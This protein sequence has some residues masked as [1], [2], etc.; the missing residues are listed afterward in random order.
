M[1]KIFPLLILSCLL[2]FC[3][4]E[5]KLLR[6]AANAVERTQFD[7]AVAAYDQ[8]LKKDSNSF[9][10][11]AGKG[12]VLSEFMSRHEQAIPYLETALKNTPDKTKPILHKNLGKSY[13]FVGNYERALFYYKKSEKDND[14]TWADYDAFLSKRIADCKYAIE[15]PKIATPE[16]Q[17]IIN[18][19]T[20]INTEFPEYTPVVLGNKI[21]F[22]SKRQDDPKEK[23][24]QMDGK[25]FEAIYV[26]D[27]NADGTIGAPQRYTIPKSTKG[28]EAVLSATP[29]GKKLLVY[30]SGKIYESD[31][32][33]STHSTTMLD[34]KINFS[35]LQDHAS[36][37]P[38]G[39]TI[40]FT[41]E[42]E[43]GYGGTDIFYATKKQDGT[44]SD[45]HL[46]DRAINTEFDEE[47]PFITESGILYFASNGHPGYGGFDVFKS[48]QVNGVWSKAENIG[49]PINSP[50]DDI[51]FSLYP[52]SSKGYYASA[53]PGGHGDL[54]IYKVHYVSSE[55][56][57]CEKD[58]KL[59]IVNS[60]DPSNP[61]IQTLQVTV[62]DEYR[63]K[64]KSYRWEINGETLPE[65]NSSLRHTFTKADNYQIS[66]QLVVYCDSCP[67][68]LAKCAVK[69]IQIEQP[70]ILTD[71]SE[72]DKGE[73]LN[74]ATA[75]N[76]KGKKGNKNS[77]G[78]SLAS[79]SKSSATDDQHMTKTKN[80]GAQKSTG[81][82]VQANEDGTNGS[83][84]VLV[85]NETG[86]SKS[87][88][89]DAKTAYENSSSNMLTESEL[90]SMNWNT[91]PGTFEYNISSI[92]SNTAKILDHNIEILK[93]NKDLMLHITGHADSRGTNQYNKELSLRRAREV[94]SYFTTHGVSSSRIKSVEG[95]GEE[96]LVNNC[97]DGVDCSEEQHLQNRRV[98]VKVSNSR[99]S[100]LT[101]IK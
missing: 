26:A 11:N 34:D 49:Q 84:T 2:S 54:D 85:S 14:P 68:L 101:Q 99:Q 56:T 18:A 75:S 92:N 79:G 29:D 87:S 38:D 22:T 55:T 64:V 42:A 70:K 59:S 24:N 67:N 48:R 35:T 63:D 21:Y 62:P 33:S 4:Q 50:G 61:L 15:H 52:N 78:E 10:G 73:P 97:G 6:Q 74:G 51:Y 65:T 20:S 7:K 30:K 41:S 40:Y 16:N 69:Q 32:S 66:A 31:L 39:N 93:S 58:D 19:G 3:S 95:H 12:I 43:D 44:W 46:L 45:A 77:K 57:P 8:I 88:G 89:P 91:S 71:N 25:Y 36:L 100:S 23:R 13:H 98:E 72:K 27:L 96:E 60:P 1:K 80:T 5:Q 37:S 28:G 83:E 47:A 9:F 81:N 17:Q 90:I 86:N 76:S 53:R 94:K 82:N